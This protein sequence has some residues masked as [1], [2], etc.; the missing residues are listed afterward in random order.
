MPKRQGYRLFDALRRAGS[1]FV[2]GAPDPRETRTERIARLGPSPQALSNRARIEEKVRFREFRRTQGRPGITGPFGFTSGAVAPIAPQIAAGRIS[3][4][5]GTDVGSELNRL[6]APDPMAFATGARAPEFVGQELDL[7]AAGVTAA[8]LENRAASARLP[9]EAPMLQ[10]GLDVGEQEL[11]ERRAAEVQTEALRPSELELAQQAPRLGEL[12]IATAERAAAGA[13]LPEELQATRGVTQQLLETQAGQ[14]E[15]APLIQALQSQVETA[16]LQGDFDRARQLEDRIQGL[17]SGGVGPP[18]PGGAPPIS[19]GN[20]NPVMLER[21]NA[22]ATAIGQATGLDGA[23]AMLNDVAEQTAWPSSAGEQKLQTAL[24]TIERALA[25][26]PN[27]QSRDILRA[28]IRNSEGYIGIKQRAA[29][30]NIGFALGKPLST[31]PALIG[32]DGGRMN[33]M[34]AAAQQIVELI[35]GS[36][37][38]GGA[39]SVR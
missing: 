9:F 36:A 39:P 23:I 38:P 22:E 34:K 1:A 18:A 19:T 20:V 16:N 28:Q 7:G 14:A 24:G 29:Q 10:Q 33:R 12:D 13:P 15:T 6:T 25:M 26:A 35:E 4:R 31:I 11:L 27:E 17:L 8:E 32:G 21:R 3:S 2:G 30:S 37:A 5:L